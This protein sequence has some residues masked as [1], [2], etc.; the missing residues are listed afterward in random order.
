MKVL[1]MI[2]LLSASLL[3]GCGSDKQAKVAPAETVQRYEKE[4]LLQGTVSAESLIKT[5]KV[6]ARL[7]NGQLL[8]EMWLDNSARYQLSIPAGTVLPVILSYMAAETAKEREKMISVVVQT[9]ISR[10][11][12]NPLTTAIARQAK[13]LGGYTLR[14]MTQAAADSVHVPDANKTSTGF[15]GDPTTQYGG[16]H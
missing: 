14:N 7:P 4:V 15:R 9:G 3:A 5:G 10:F 1:V 2:G 16:W 8:A 11:D 12:I 6:E 13:T